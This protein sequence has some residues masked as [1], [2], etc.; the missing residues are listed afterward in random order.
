MINPLVHAPN[1]VVT[2]FCFLISFPLP[3]SPLPLSLRLPPFCPPTSLLH[4][5][6]LSRFASSR[7]R[8]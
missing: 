6:S 2:P 4:V 1:R 8:R 5:I 3:L 7:P